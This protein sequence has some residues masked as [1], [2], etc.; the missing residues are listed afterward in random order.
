[1]KLNITFPFA[2]VQK[3]GARIGVFFLA[4]L[5]HAAFAASAIVDTA[6]VIDAQKRGAIIWDTRAAA[7]Y[8]AGHIPGAINI[9]DIGNE[10]RDEQREDYIAL[11]KI[12]KLLGD[13]GID[14]TKE[15]VVYGLKGNPYVYFGLVSLQYFS[16]ANAKIY[17]G[18]I[19]DWKTAG[20]MV[21][22]EPS[23]LPPIALKIKL[24][25]ELMVDTEEVRRKLRDPKVQIVDVRTPAEYRGEDIRAIRG[26]HIPGA[27]SINYLENQVDPDAAVK[28]EKKLVANK[29]GINLKP[30]EELLKLYAKLDPEKET[31][32]Y[33]QSG[34]R[35]SETATV[36][37]DL[38]FKN[39]RV[40]D[41]SWI[42]YGSTLDAPAEDVTFFNV[43]NMTGKITALQRRV[44][45]LERELAAAKAAK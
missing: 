32:V 43:G 26:G 44:E 17:H 19:D 18:G 11:T 3:T 10:L 8:K 30:R 9:G 12:E 14:P 22:T 31:I 1:M 39:V 5:A 27:V 16:A 7:M 41:A 20:Q 2:A 36:L 25:P 37:A 35:A 40:Y 33:C 4:A 24:R 28:I 15:I 38:G 29:D 21:A 23:K 45:G 6:Y 13:A 42:G 34:I